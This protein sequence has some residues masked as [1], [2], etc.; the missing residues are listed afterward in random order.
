MKKK[1]KRKKEERGEVKKENNEGNTREKNK[2][3]TSVI[4]KENLPIRATCY[5]RFAS[6]ILVVS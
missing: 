6:A 1:K 4:Y 3:V 2:N 5:S